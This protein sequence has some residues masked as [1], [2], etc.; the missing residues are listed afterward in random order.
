MIVRCR[1]HATGF[2]IREAMDNVA[3]AALENK[4][5]E[6]AGHHRLGSRGSEPADS[7]PSHI[8]HGSDLWQSVAEPGT[9]GKNGALSEHLL[10][11]GAHQDA[12][13]T[14]MD[15]GRLR[16]HAVVG[17][18]TYDSKR[19]IG[20]QNGPAVLD[21]HIPVGRQGERREFLICRRR[22]SVRV[23]DPPGEDPDIARRWFQ[24]FADIVVKVFLGWRRKIL[25]AADAFY[26][27]RCEGPYRF[28]QNRSRTFVVALKSDAA[29]ER[30]KNR[31]SRDF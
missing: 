19:D 2:E 16:K 29:A 8:E 23:F 25:K 3:R 22:V 1:F 31:F 6:S 9:K 21:D 15:L 30:S 5:W 18:R 7:L 11:F 4:Q 20:F 26:A 14:V 17:A 12:V 28:I 27:L 13:R 24:V 10:C